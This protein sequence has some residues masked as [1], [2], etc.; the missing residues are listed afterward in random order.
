MPETVSKKCSIYCTNSH[1]S[2]YTKLA[3]LV[4]VTGA[5]S[6]IGKKTV[7]RLLESGY[8]VIGLA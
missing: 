3:K 8:Q 7:I 4:I 5:S 6:G 2:T 1:T